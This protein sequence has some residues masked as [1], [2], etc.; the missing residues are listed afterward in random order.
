[1]NFIEL[2][3]DKE[4]LLLNVNLIETVRPYHS[5]AKIFMAGST[6]DEYWITDESYEEILHLLKTMY[7]SETGTNYD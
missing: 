4:P 2:H 7:Q 5:H 6:Y 1:M 3:I